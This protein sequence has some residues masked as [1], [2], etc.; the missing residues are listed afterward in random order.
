MARPEG[1]ESTTLMDTHD[2]KSFPADAMSAAGDP[3]DSTAVMLAAESLA[4]ASCPQ[5]RYQHLV[6]AEVMEVS[7]G[8]CMVASRRAVEATPHPHPSI[9]GGDFNA[10]EHSHEIRGLTEIAGWLDTFRHLNPDDPGHTWG[11]SLAAATAT[12]GRRID[13]LFS[14]PD[15][16][17]HW[18]PRD[19][20][21]VLNAAFPRERDGVLWASDHYGVLTDFEA[22]RSRRN[23]TP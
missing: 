22:P 11:Q 13:F 12:A 2:T 7:E 23:R 14:A 9:V 3:G 21:L 18:E 17:E 1:T 19:S 5:P 10:E 8:M 20:R 16:G 6:E 4:D 15:A